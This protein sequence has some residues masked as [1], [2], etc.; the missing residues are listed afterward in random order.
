MKNQRLIIYW[1]FF[2][3][4]WA[5]SPGSP[6]FSGQKKQDEREYTIK[7]GFIYNFT[8]FIQWPQGAFA[9]GQEKFIIG[10]VGVNP[11]DDILDDIA[12]KKEIKGRG[13][14]VEYYKSAE[15][16]RKCHIL[17][18]ASSE[19]DNL[20]KILEKV[21]KSPILL[22]GDTPDFGN[23]GVAFNFFV[24]RDKLRFEINIKHMEEAG[25]IA[26]SQLLSLGKIIE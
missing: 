18:I 2:S 13:M 23:K 15:E 14:V 12:A 24:K 26:G 4:L 7:A 25:L 17:F 11:F 16:I 21:R 6:A 10:V 3:F 5:I 8:E 20:E 19:K 1:I 22:I 9:N